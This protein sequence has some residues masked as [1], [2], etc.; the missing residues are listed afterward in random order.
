[1][2]SNAVNSLK[3]AGIVTLSLQYKGTNVKKQ[4]YQKHNAG[5]SKLFNFFTDCLIGDWELAKL[6]RPTKIRLLNVTS[7]AGQEKVTPVSDFLYLV[8]TN[9]EKLFNEDIRG[10]V[11]RFTFIVPSTMLGAAFNRI[12]LYANDVGIDEPKKYSAYCDYD[13]G[14]NNKALYGA[15]SVLVVDWDLRLSNADE[16]SA[17]SSITE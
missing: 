10:E 15:S 13:L 17:S 8:N 7:V 3:Y 14:N 2:K 5:T 16:A 1:M 6:E 9:P 12:G 4:I 11:V